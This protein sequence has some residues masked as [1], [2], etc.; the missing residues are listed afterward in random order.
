MEPAVR[1]KTFLKDQ[2]SKGKI[3]KKDLLKLEA[4]HLIKISQ[5]KDIDKETISETLQ[6]IKYQ[7]N[8]KLI[9]EGL[10]GLFEK[11]KSPLGKQI[12]DIMRDYN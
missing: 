1:I 7:V 2:I 4:S 6:A 5:L 9:D 11:K 12:D 10:Q 8:P 3:S